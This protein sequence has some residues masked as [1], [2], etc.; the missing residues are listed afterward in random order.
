MH[1]VLQ[2][3][4][5]ALHA[6]AVTSRM[7]GRANSATLLWALYQDLLNAVPVDTPVRFASSAPDWFANNLLR[8]P[9][10]PNAVA[11]IF[12]NGSSPVHAGPCWTAEDEIIFCT[13]I[14]EAV[15]PNA[16]LTA[17]ARRTPRQHYPFWNAVFDLYSVPV[18]DDTWTLSPYAMMVPANAPAPVSTADGRARFFPGIVQMC[19]VLAQDQRLSEARLRAALHSPSAD[20]API[21]NVV[22]ETFALLTCQNLDLVPSSQGEYRFVTRDDHR[23][24]TSGAVTAAPNGGAV[25]TPGALWAPTTNRAWRIQ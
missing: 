20:A 5:D 1:A 9:P 19:D 7:R 11:L 18:D 6:L 13:S 23:A 15:V 25:W 8:V 21:F 16:L 12:R 24:L 3:A 14:T 22:A 10:L 4:S 2:D 17:A